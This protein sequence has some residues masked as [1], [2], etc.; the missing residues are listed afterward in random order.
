MSDPMTFFVSP[1]Q[2]TIVERASHN[3]MLK[4]YMQ[5]HPLSQPVRPLSTTSVPP[6]LRSQLQGFPGPLE[7]R[8]E[9]A[10]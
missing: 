3:I 9:E 7:C 2:P 8:I 6:A 1:W 10:W 4:S 5:P